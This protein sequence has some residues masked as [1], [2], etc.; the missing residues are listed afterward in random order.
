[1]DCVLGW[2][3]SGC[4]CALQEPFKLQVLVRTT[5][6][7]SLVQ[8]NRAVRDDCALRLQ[9]AG[10]AERGPLRIQMP[11]RPARQTSRSTM[12]YCWSSEVHAAQTWDPGGECILP[13]RPPVALIP[14]PACSSWAPA[15]AACASE[16]LYV[17]IQ[18]GATAH[19][20]C[21]DPGHVQ[22]AT[23][24]RPNSRWSH[25]AHSG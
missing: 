15:F 24:S 25:R 16:A 2:L 6:Y 1:M 7:H 5:I 14:R 13:G 19:L 22:Q 12:Y 21:W 23:V 10:P 3:I 18:S 17:A 8:D 4:S 20:R 9:R 11:R